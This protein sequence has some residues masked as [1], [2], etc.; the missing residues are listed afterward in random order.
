M[1][2]AR[3]PESR[4][5]APFKLTP[6]QGCGNICKYQLGGSGLTVQDIQA[7]ETHVQIGND[8]FRPDRDLCQ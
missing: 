6:G 4:I 5:V 7:T 8:T 3:D 2:N 1:V